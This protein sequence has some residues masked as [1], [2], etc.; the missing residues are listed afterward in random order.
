MNKS[1][2]K[3]GQYLAGVIVLSCSLALVSSRF[4]S[5]TGWLS[6]MIVGIIAGALIIAVLKLMRLEQIPTWLLV[7]IIAAG[8]LRL[9]AGS[10]WYLA[11]PVFGHNTPAEQ[12]GYVMGDAAGRDQAAWRL[13]ASGKPLLSAFQDQ[14]KVD[15]YGGLLYLS[16]AV[17]RYLG[18]KI[19]QPLL[20]VLLA[21]AFSSLAVLFSWAFSRRLW[22]ATAAAVSAWAIALYPEAVL[23]GSSQMREAFTIPLAAASFYGLVRYRDDHTAGNLAWILVPFLGALFFSPLSAALILACLFLASLSL[24][25]LNTS[26]NRMPGWLWIFGLLLVLIVILSV[27]IAL[28]ENVPARITNPIS[29]LTW[30]LKKSA[31]LQAYLSQHASGWAQKLFKLTPDWIHLPLLLIYGIV[32]PFL[33]AAFVAGSQAVIWRGIAI[34]R[35][36]GWTLLLP[37]MIYAPFYTSQKKGQRHIIRVF[38]LI[39]WIVILISAFRG[40]GDLWDNP[41]Y[42]ALFACLQTALA[43]KIWVDARESHDPWMRRIA[44][45]AC[46]MLVWFFPWYLYRYYGFLWP[47]Q[48][49]FYILILG[50]LTSLAWMSADWYWLNKIG[51]GRSERSNSDNANPPSGS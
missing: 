44:I 26:Q 27:W 12:G 48:N 50:I 3:I 37:F 34:W 13:A 23:L 24:L 20:I 51:P 10:F 49:P 28:R 36:L 9:A 30:W 19:H 46:S 35:A 14:R 43:A 2:I 32:Q 47:I 4:T 1:I 8:L 5:I 7:L 11:L 33:P 31:S 16:S 40:G 21:S 25:Q 45:L 22:G 15:Q 38:A 29:M 6:F 41:R 17:Y 42:R 39:V 18:G